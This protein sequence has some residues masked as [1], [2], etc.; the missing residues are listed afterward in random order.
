MLSISR[1]LLDEIILYCK[2]AYPNETCGILAG[3]GNVIERVYKIKNISNNSQIIYEMEPVE[4]LRCEREIKAAGLKLLGIYHS[5]PSSE[6][7]PSQTDVMRAYW[8]GDPDLLI[9]PDACYMI[10]GPVDGK[11]DVRVFTI[12]TGQKVN[13]I[14]LNVI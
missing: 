2:D 1:K 12:N 10:V 4:Q 3:R 6:A 14:R 9:Y 8:P 7:Y 11:T 13:E 5:H